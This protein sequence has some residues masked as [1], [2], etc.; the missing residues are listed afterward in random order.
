[1]K[2]GRDW[3]AGLRASLAPCGLNHVG[4]ASIAAWDE[5]ARP[6][7]RSGQVFPGARAIV[8]V[9]SGGP[10]LWEAFLEACRE[11]AGALL[12]HEHPLDAFV[13]RAVASADPSGTWH[14]A[15]AGEALPLDF[16]TLAVL[17]GLGA[18]SRLGL[19]LDPGWGPWL[20]LRAAR[21]VPWELPP[22]APAEDLCGGCPGPCEVACPGEAFVDHRWSVQRCAAFHEQADTCARSCAARAACPV[23]AE[24]IYPPLERLYH[25]NRGEGRAALRAH[26]GL[27]VERDPH[28]GSG[29]SWGSWSG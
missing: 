16:R 9:A 14:F 2:E 5:R 17:A 18:P 15:A 25:D 7:T 22:G 19:V 29:P 20:G 26:L 21:F 6:E 23:G 1:M 8:V 24:H 28:R 12:D 11:D 10:R 27:S 13:R 3:L 4:V